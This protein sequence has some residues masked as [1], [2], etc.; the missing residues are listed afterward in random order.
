MKFLLDQGLPRSTIRHLA[1]LG[2]SAEHVGDLGLAVA[3]DGAILDTARLG[4]ATVVTLD[5]DFHKMLA[6]SHAKAPSVVR[7]RVEGLKGDELAR[8]L[9]RVIAVASFDLER[10]AVISVSETRIRVRSL[11]IGR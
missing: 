8:L 6:S 7:I 5:A 1:A 2:V 4:G 3:T 10:G 9:M 11:P